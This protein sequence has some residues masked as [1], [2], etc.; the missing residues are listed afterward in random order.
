[1]LLQSQPWQRRSDPGN[2][3][4]GQPSGNLSNFWFGERSSPG[5]KAASDRRRH[6]T[7][8]R[9]PTGAGACERTHKHGTHLGA[10]VGLESQK[11]RTSFFF[12]FFCYYIN[13]PVYCRLGM[14]RVDHFSWSLDSLSILIVNL[15]VKAEVEE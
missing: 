6:P 8:S 1:M 7:S 5:N 3:L 14:C 4:A 11:T 13:R 15:T 2:S 10:L 9:V 12:F